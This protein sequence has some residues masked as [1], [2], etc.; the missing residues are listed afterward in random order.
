MRRMGFATALMIAS[1]FLSRFVGFAREMIIASQEG[2][3]GSTDAYYAA[4]TLP[5]LLNYFL[6]GGTLSITF[7]PLF[8]SYL[9]RD[10][11]QEGWTLFSTI[12]S[13][14]GL[15]T[16]F[17]VVLGEVGAPHFVPWF[18]D[19][20]SQEQIALCVRMTRIVTPGMLC[21]TIG[22]LVQGTLM[23]RERFREVAAVPV[24]YNL[25]IILGGVLLGPWVGV[26]GFAWGALSGAIVGP[27]AIPL[28]ASRKSIRYRFNLNLSSEGFRKYLKLALPLMMGVSLISLDEWYLR[29]FG[30]RID[31]GTITCLN[32]AR[33]LMLVPVAIIGQAASQAALPFLS[34]LWAKKDHETFATTLVSAMRNVLFYAVIAAGALFVLSE[35]IIF[36]AFQRGAYTPEDAR[37]T[38]LFLSLLAFGTIAWSGQNVIARGYYARENT[39]EPMLIGTVVAA[40][41]YPVY[42]ILAENYGGMGLSMASSVG[43]TLNALIMTLVF[44]WRHAPISLGGLSKAVML[45]L[46]SA[47]PGGGAAYGVLRGLDGYLSLESTLEAMILLVIGGAVYL[48]ITLGIA[49]AL[50]AEELSFLRKVARKILQKMGR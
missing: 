18:F 31:E 44:R 43:I 50:K 48:V 13:A 5:D 42:S 10:K 29:R 11:E 21:F 2:A 17:A 47:V 9:A 35:P 33:R 37:A 46:V 27:L 4:F 32:N 7:I 22:G 3:T 36:V 34:K 20:F 8:S 19:G 15:L 14:V 16:L 40:A 23:A 24:V 49:F 12:S 45:S 25:F 41:S 39:L 30:S 6:A 28:W 26:E 1:V 38:A